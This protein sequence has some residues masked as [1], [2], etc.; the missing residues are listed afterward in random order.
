MA[1]RRRRTL[2][3]RVRPLDRAAITEVRPIPRENDG[4]FRPIERPDNRL[5]PDIPGLLARLLDAG[6]D[7]VVVG[8]AGAALLGADVEPGD[9]DIS[10]DLD[11]ANLARLAAVLGELDARPRMG[12][13]GWITEEE[14]AVAARPTLEALDYDF[15]TSLG[16]LDLIVRPLGPKPSDDLAYAA[17][18]GSARPVAVGG[19]V[20]RVADAEHLVA[21]KLGAR[22]PKDLRVREELERIVTPNG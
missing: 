15:D 17:L 21:S 4:T 10:P 16:D 20:V 19:R 14:R 12:V 7:F 11:P 18:I 13:P 5:P 8:S 22:R 9:L 2:P 3:A 1:L 6:V